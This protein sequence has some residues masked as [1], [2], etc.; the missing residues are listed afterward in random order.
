MAVIVLEVYMYIAIL[1]MGTPL[2]KDNRVMFVN[3]KQEFIFTFS[4]VR[5]VATRADWIAY[6]YSLDHRQCPD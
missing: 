1:V 3:T 4:F 2:G 5:D 6:Y